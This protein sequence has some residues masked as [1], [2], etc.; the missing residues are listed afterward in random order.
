MKPYSRTL[1]ALQVIGL[2][3]MACSTGAPTPSAQTPTRQSK[4]RIGVDA[5]LAPFEVLDPARNELVGLDIDLMRAITAKA[6]IPLEFVN[7]EFNQLIT[8]IS[9]CRLDGGISAI[10]ISDAFKGQM[11]FSQPY[12]TTGHGVVVKKGNLTITSRDQLGDTIVGTQT[13]TPSEAEIK[14]LRG[15]QA[16]TYTNFY[17]AFQDLAEG[18]IDAVIADIP[19][20]VS[21]INVKPNNLKLVGEPF[22]RVQYGIASCK[23][24]VELA[25]KIDDGLAA[26][27]GDGTLDQ[28]THKWIGGGGP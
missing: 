11:N 18:Y 12:Y 6:D 15:V 27:K 5:S 25:K 10:P 7:L 20:A 16:K 9:Q 19:R 2:L 4:F 21:A 14:N 3:L 24:Q 23:T 17:F 1:I 28:L 13:G 22:G 8:A 26:V